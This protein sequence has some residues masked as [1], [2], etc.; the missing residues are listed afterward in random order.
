MNV[1]YKLGGNTK[2]GIDCSGFVYMIYNRVYEKKVPRTSIK[3]FD[4]CKKI[5]THKLQE[6]DLVFF[7]LNEKE[8]S[9]VGIYLTH[10]QFVHASVSKGV[11]IS[12][13]SESYYARAFVSGGRL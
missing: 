10:S 3:L 4:A 1:P 6:G 5:P 13:L 7:K 8:V 2:E 11:I 12:S 9:H